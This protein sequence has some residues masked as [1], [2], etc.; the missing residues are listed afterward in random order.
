MTYIRMINLPLLSGRF[1]KGGVTERGGGGTRICLPI[2]C[3]FA[4]PDR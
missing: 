2:H 3:L 1:K 4:S